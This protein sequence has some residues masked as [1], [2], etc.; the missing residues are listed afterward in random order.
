MQRMKDFEEIEKNEKYSLKN[1]RIV[2]NP[3]CW[4]HLHIILCGHISDI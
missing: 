2:Y 3:L 4:L 1:I